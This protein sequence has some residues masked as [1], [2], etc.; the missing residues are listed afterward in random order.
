MAAGT[1]FISGK[2]SRHG[3][4]HLSR[5]KA[6]ELGSEVKALSC[7]HSSVQSTKGSGTSLTLPAVRNFWKTG[8][9]V[10]HFIAKL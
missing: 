8:R 6:R 5:S 4:L 3:L 10:G 2:S 7:A 1:L 9:S